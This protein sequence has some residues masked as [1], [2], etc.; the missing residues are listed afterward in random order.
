MVEER[1]HE[2]ILSVKNWIAKTVLHSLCRAILKAVHSKRRRR[3]GRL[4][5]DR[6]CLRGD[7]VSK[8]KA[9]AEAKIESLCEGVTEGQVYA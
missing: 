6:Q 7:P 1:S 9:V 8:N 5:C 4:R 2:Q 3:Q